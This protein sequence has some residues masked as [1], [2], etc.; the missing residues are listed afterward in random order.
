MPICE[1]IILLKGKLVVEI[2]MKRCLS[3]VIGINEYLH[4]PKL[5][6]AVNDARAVAD[7]FRKLKYEVR[8][9][10]DSAATKKNFCAIFDEVC[11]RL[12]VKNSDIDVFV[13]YFAGHGR[14]INAS[15]CLILH[16]AKDMKSNAATLKEDTIVLSSLCQDLRTYGN[17]INI[18]ILD[19]CRT[20]DESGTRGGVSQYV[21]EFGKNTVIP[22]QTYTAFS[23][24]P[25]DGAND[26]GGNG[27]SPF[28][29][30][31][32]A[33][34]IKEGQP[35]E[36][37]FK[38]IRKKIFS[39][40]GDPLPCETSCL[41]DDFSFNYGQLEPR[42]YAPYSEGAYDYAHFSSPAIESFKNHL[43]LFGIR[44]T[45]R[46][47]AKSNLTQD[48]AF[49]FGTKMLTTTLKDN[50]AEELLTTTKLSEL[51]MDVLCGFFYA[52]FYDT[53]RNCRHKNIPQWLIDRIELLSK[54]DSKN[55]TEAVAFIR[56]FDS[57]EFR[58]VVHYLPGD[59]Q[60]HSLVLTL[61]D[62][63][64]KLQTSNIYYLQQITLDGQ[65]IGIRWDKNL[66][67]DEQTLKS[68]IKA[69][70]NIPSNLLTIRISPNIPNKL[71]APIEII[72]IETDLEQ[73][74]AENAPSDI[75]LD[76]SGS[77][78]EVD[79]VEV[80]NIKEEN[81]QVILQG[82]C[83]TT[84]TYTIDHEDFHTQ[85]FGEIV[86]AL[87]EDENHNWHVDHLVE[88]HIHILEY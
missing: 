3:I 32:L 50:E 43:Q 55:V 20:L 66:L 10:Y 81:G 52:M 31:L 44:D 35:I 26:T 11:L 12:N 67:R 28:T 54:N 47:V 30:A 39:K 22:Y 34:M 33:E 77:R 45:W 23:T 85:A 61:K 42:N 69:Q 21:K 49:V 86:V 4:N 41:V 6:N 24:S 15:D 7:T 70:L 71:I 76:F 13:L 79:N 48:E 63:G 88:E 18:L 46:S 17:Q 19:A 74:F 73:L 60:Q 80:S 56:N 68:Y 16:D 87:K 53:K 59:K 1:G 14:M 84:I 64:Y 51:P 37:T 57:D 27:H 82:L 65:P 75:E 40:E 9:L 8:T 38:N 5:H 83:Q 72:N 78:I 25:G 2:K 62:V 58:E 36:I 29:E